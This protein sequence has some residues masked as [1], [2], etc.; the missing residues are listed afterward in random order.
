MAGIRS[1]RSAACLLAVLALPAGAQEP[2]ELA[3]PSPVAPAAPPV[4]APA[5]PLPD[6]VDDTSRFC[7]ISRHA[8]PAA[9]PAALVGSLAINPELLPV[10]SLQAKPGFTYSNIDMLNLASTAATTGSA[11]GRP[12]PN[13]G[14]IDASGYISANIA[15]APDPVVSLMRLIFTDDGKLNA[16]RTY[17][18][19]RLS[20]LPFWLSVFYVALGMLLVMLLLDLL[21]GR[22]VLNFLNKASINA[23]DDL[24]LLKRAAKPVRRRKRSL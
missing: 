10:E 9:R 21:R 6:C 20:S 18:L 22:S 1:R 19:Q 11:A 2:V 23:I 12:R 13:D 4:D 14:T 8:T 5:G 15:L 17:F 3:L 7:R 16:N 24:S